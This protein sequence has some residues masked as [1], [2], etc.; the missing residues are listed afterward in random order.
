M[1]TEICT[2]QVRL[3]CYTAG[4]R[5]NVVRLFGDPRV[6]ELTGNGPCSREPALQLFQGILDIY[7]GSQPDRLFFI[8]AVERAGVYIGHVELKETADTNPR[9]LEIV[10]LLDTPHW[11]QG[12]GT[13]LIRAIRT[14]AALIGRS[15]IATV[16][17]HNIPSLGLLR[18]VGVAE[19]IR[20]DGETIKLV[21]KVEP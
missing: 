2:A 19:E 4:D 7:A 18:K 13:E 10:Y 21:L 15:V 17:D 12:I 14:H 3:R 5:E 20:L 11:R 8:W 9:E 6:N 1:Q 16:N